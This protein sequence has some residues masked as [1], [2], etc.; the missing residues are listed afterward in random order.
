MSVN[1][2]D[3]I[4]CGK[5]GW[6]AFGQGLFT[7]LLSVIGLGS[8]VSNIPGMS[9]QQDAQNNLTSAQAALS[10]ATTQWGQ[11]IDNE[12]TAII[13]DTDVL[14]QALIVASNNQNA[15]IDETLNEKIENNSSLISVIIILVVFLILFDIV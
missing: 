2:S 4:S 3:S 10:T 13:Q 1:F 8:T 5:Q 14:L 6:K 9:A 15:V 11:A 7:G 12:K